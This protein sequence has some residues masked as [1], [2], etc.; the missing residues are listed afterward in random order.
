M[1]NLMTARYNVSN[2]I[3]ERFMI[4]KIR[5]EKPKSL[6]TASKDKTKEKKLVSCSHDFTLQT[7]DGSGS[8]TLSDT[9]EG[10]GGCFGFSCNTWLHGT[11][12]SRFK[13]CEDKGLQRCMQKSEYDP[14][15]FSTERVL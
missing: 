15:G 13:S 6:L 11:L 4:L 7:L 12:K 9:P 2:V 10:E 14:R 3:E 1:E 8:V 5:A